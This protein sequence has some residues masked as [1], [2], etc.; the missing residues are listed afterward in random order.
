M[1]KDHNLSLEIRI[2]SQK[3]VLIDL[4]ISFPVIEEN[5]FKA[6]F[7]YLKQFLTITT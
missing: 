5:K 2:N 4:V 7:V 6:A 3:K 1:R